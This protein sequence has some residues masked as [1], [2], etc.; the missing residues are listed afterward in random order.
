M[1]EL[2]VGDPAPDF[3]LPKTPDGEFHLADLRGKKHV[4]LSVHVLDFTGDD[5][6]G[7]FCQIHTW[8]DHYPRI[9][10]ADGEVVE[11]SAD[12]IFAHR[13][14]LQD[15]GEV[16]FPLA[17][18]FT[19]NMLRQYGIL[20]E[21]NGYPVRS[22]FVIDKNGEIRYKNTQFN[23]SDPAQYEEAIKALEACK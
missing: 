21:T 10:A 9:Q 23:A 11:V 17:A 19:K 18:D 6:R 2:N 4:L 13:R 20:N 7:C 14:Y 12:S 1:P 5:S 16:P 3:N 22:V 8:R 15:L